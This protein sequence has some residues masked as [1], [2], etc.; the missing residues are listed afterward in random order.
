M[1]LDIIIDIKQKLYAV[2]YNF[3]KKSLFYKMH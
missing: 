2:A 1:Y 3:K